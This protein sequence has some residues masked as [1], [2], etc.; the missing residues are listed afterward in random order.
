MKQFPKA[1]ER[2]LSTA[3]RLFYEQGFQAT[4][5]NQIIEEAGIAKASLY[6]HFK[7]KDDLLLEYLT[8]SDSK[9][10]EHLKAFLPAKADGR[11]AI[12]GL[13]DYRK[14]IALAGDSKGCAFIRV[15]YELPLLTHDALKIIQ[16][17]KS[18]LKNFIR[19]NIKILDNHA[20]KDAEELTELILN[21]Y[22]GCGIQSTL[23]RSV[24]PII[25]AKK[26][27]K[28]LLN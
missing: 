19:S 17:H 2:I 24:E 15:A 14:K 4:G 27:A 16:S 26:I 28:K 10:F 9:W 23:L 18:K 5:I 13:F 20:P 8:I 22:E 25:G 7:S 6:Q 3:S 1:K 11:A 21:L 12:L